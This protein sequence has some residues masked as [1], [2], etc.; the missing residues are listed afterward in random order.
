MLIR[1]KH[2]WQGWAGIVAAITAGAC[3]GD[4]GG[5]I[6]GS[7]D[8]NATSGPAAAGGSD[9]LGGDGGSAANGGGGGGGDGAKLPCDVDALFDKSCRSCH[10]T[11]TSY[12]APMPLV[13]YADLQAPWKGG[14][15]YEHLKD[16]VHA[17]V[18]PMP[19][20]PNPR[21]DA[22][23]M[24]ALDAWV[25][26]GAK[27]G[28]ETCHGGGGAPS[29]DPPPLSCT[30]D[31]KL[32]P[33]SPGTIAQGTID[34]YLC[35]GVELPS[36]TDRHVIAMAPHIDNKAILHHL[37][38]F[39]SDVAVSAQPTPC[40]AGGSAAWRLYGGWAP[41]GGNIELPPAAGVRENGNTHWVVQVHLNNSKGLVGQTDTS[42]FDFCSTDK[43]RP[44]DAETM[45]FGSINFSIPPRATR[46]LACDWSVPAYL[47]NLHVF[48]M[49]PHMHKLGKAMSSTIVRGGTQTPLV[50]VKAF[51]FS[52][53]SSYPTNLDIKAGDTIRTHCVWNNTTDQ[54]VSFGENTGNEMC[55]D[56]AFYYPKVTT[57]LWSW[58][59]P[60]LTAVCN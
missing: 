32:R 30:P 4:P 56:F 39:Q 35:Y 47:G 55:F 36:P 40:S 24:A 43:L 5:A 20:S 14:K 33:A 44:N 25:D 11:T 52:S 22:A 37:L 49:S 41:G 38:L 26:G 34:Q 18:S 7:G 58:T 16:R 48:A 46:D 8:S 51:D 42:G 50:D 1:K 9:V 54:V 3:G 59:T 10:G 28:T 12:G 19:P 21:L 29:G 17:D 45:A 57:P 23:A 15:V 6:A 31:Q 2:G 27:P 53:Q 13:T 60:S